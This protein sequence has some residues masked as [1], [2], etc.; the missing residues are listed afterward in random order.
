M[1]YARTK[2][3]LKMTEKTGEKQNR[4]NTEQKENKNYESDA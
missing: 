4:L 3:T 1:T 2:T